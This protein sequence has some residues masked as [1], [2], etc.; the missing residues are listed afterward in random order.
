M[1]PVLEPLMEMHAALGTPATVGAGPYGMRQIF[2]VA[3]GEFAG[4]RLRGEI[5]PGGGDWAL[6]GA[7]GVARLDVRLTLRT[8]DGASLYV[9]YGGVLHLNDRVLQV[10]SGNGSMEYGDTYFFT[11]PR[12]ETGDE[13]YAWLN[14]VAAVGQGKLDPGRV[15]YR[16]FQ[17]A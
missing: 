4:A 14:G 11:S 17:L 7:D 3:G 10:L 2:S 8:H 1:P 16:V 15:S 5:L 9:S 12:F 6:L 13:R